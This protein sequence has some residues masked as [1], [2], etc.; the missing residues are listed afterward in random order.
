MGTQGPLWASFS[1]SR[2]EWGTNCAERGAQGTLAGNK[3][4]HLET[5][6]GSV[7]VIFQIVPRKK[8]SWNPSSFLEGFCVAF[9]VPGRGF[10]CNPYPPVQSKRT[11]LFSFFFRKQLPKESNLG[12][13]LGTI[14]IEN[15]NCVRKRDATN[16]QGKSARPR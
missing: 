3:V 12:S 10:T 15:H 13:M 8:G 16:R 1:S 11:C 7:F 14:F 6:R 4:I 5:F 9:G 2:T